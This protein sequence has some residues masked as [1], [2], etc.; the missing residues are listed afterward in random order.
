VLA[1]LVFQHRYISG[2]PSPEKALIPTG[3]Y[4]SA[5]LRLVQ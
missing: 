5:H 3:P 4:A 1:R 2:D